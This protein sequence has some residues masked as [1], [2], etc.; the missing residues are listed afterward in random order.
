MDQPFDFISKLLPLIDSYHQEAE[1][2]L[3]L[4]KFTLWLNKQ[5]ILSD[6]AQKKQLDNNHTV[7][8][9]IAAMFTRMGKYSK[10]YTRMA[11]Q[12]SALTSLDDFVLLVSLT[13]AESMKKGELISHNL[14]E[15]PT[16]IGIINRLIKHG[17]I[18]ELED[19]EDR[20]SKRVMLTQQ[21]KDEL[22]SLFDQ[23]HLSAQIL[24]G[25][26]DNQTKIELLTLLTH[27]DRFHLKLFHDKEIE[28]LDDVY[29]KLKEY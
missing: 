20:R 13:E 17:L 23:M 28:V 3:S 18:R 2:E 19:E 29:Q 14:M 25:D 22:L 15:Y 8:S 6:P 10:H 11:L 27:L 1:G 12:D 9:H 26:L 7:D 4:E 16:G 5:L 21:G 24:T